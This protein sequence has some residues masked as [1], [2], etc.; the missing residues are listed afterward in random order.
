MPGAPTS[1]SLLNWRGHIVAISAASHPPKERPNTLTWS[2][3]RSSR[4]SRYQPAISRMFMIQSRRA[5]L[6]KPGCDGM[7][8]VLCWAR[9]WWKP[10]QPG[11]PI[12]PWRI[13][14]GSPEPPLT[15]CSCVPPASMVSSVQTWAPVVISLLPPDIRYRTCVRSPVSRSVE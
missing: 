11:W 5:D 3:A 9:A 1:T 13:S 14:N 4:A 2:R 15:I 6:P 10:S 8:S 12:S 7:Y